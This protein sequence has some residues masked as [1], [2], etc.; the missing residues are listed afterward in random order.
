VEKLEAQWIHSSQWPG[1]EKH[2]LALN[3][4]GCSTLRFHAGF[5]Q[6]KGDQRWTWVFQRA[7]AFDKAQSIQGISATLT[8]AKTKLEELLRE[9]RGQ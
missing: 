6:L 5:V 3:L 8:E 7:S 2:I 4:P 9:K 1:R